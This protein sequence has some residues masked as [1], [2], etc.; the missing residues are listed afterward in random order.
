MAS[1]PHLDKEMPMP[2]SVGASARTPTPNLSASQYCGSLVGSM[3]DPFPLSTHESFVQFGSVALPIDLDVIRG[4]LH[5]RPSAWRFAPNG[6]MPYRF[7]H[8]VAY[9]TTWPNPQD[10]ADFLADLRTSLDRLGLI[11]PLGLC[12]LGNDD[13]DGV[14]GCDLTIARSNVTVLLDPSPADETMHAQRAFC[15]NQWY[16]HHDLND[17]N[18]LIFLRL[19]PRFYRRAKR[20]KKKIIQSCVLG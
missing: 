15:F 18:W 5:C 20:Q 17:V 3:Y 16:A 8:N 9:N 7:S 6:L 2:S 11:H 13:I 4:K 12:G 14:T 19:T 10:H 1:S